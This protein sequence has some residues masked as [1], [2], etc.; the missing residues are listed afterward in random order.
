MEP[1][2]P[3]ACKLQVGVL[4]GGS[5][6]LKKALNSLFKSSYVNVSRLVPKQFKHLFL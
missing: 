2:I 5:S 1:A 4:Y 6:V 3:S